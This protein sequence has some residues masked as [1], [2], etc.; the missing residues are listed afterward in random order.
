VFEGGAVYVILG[1]CDAS[2]FPEI[3]LADDDLEEV[4]GFLIEGAETD[5][6]FG[7]V[8]RAADINGDTV[9]DIVVTAPFRDGDGVI[10]TG[11]VSIF[12]GGRG[13]GSYVAHAGLLTDP[14]EVHAPSNSLSLS[15][16][17]SV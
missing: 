14:S 9:A 2:G 10:G 7:Q 11:A 8:V 6:N 12:F 1:R 3:V 15:L 13:S 5:D 16:S 17:F 4:T